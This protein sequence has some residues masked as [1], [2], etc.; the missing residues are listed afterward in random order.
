MNVVY[1]GNKETRSV[2]KCEGMNRETTLRPAPSQRL[3]NHSPDGFNWG[4][5]GSGP[6]QLSLAILLDFTCKPDLAVKL[7]QVFKE[8]VVAKWD[9]A[10]DWRLEG[11][12]I[13]DWLDRKRN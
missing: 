9:S 11:Y 4:Y 2:T 7:H 8:E 12:Q 3:F 5:R 10:S 1:K 13:Q 6:A